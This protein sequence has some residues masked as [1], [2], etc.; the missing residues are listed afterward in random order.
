MKLSRLRG[1]GALIL[2]LLGVSILSCSKPCK[3]PKLSSSRGVYA[4]I[5]EVNLTYVIED[6]NESF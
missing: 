6:S 1:V 4:P 2:T 3:C 5:D